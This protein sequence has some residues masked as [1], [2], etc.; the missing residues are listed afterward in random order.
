MKTLLSMMCKSFDVERVGRAEE[1][2]EL[3]GFT[4]SPQGLKVRLRPRSRS[5][6]LIRM[7]SRPFFL[8][9]DRLRGGLKPKPR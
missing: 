5:C 2:T 7:A 3:F 1:V 4:M 6:A 9:R 8:D